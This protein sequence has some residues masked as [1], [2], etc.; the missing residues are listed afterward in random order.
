MTA[1][2][3]E[4]DKNKPAAGALPETDGSN[5]LKRSLINRAA[6]AGVL[7][8]ALLGGLAVLDQLNTPQP[9]K[10]AAPAPSAAST[11]PAS[12][13]APV[14]EAPKVEEPPAEQAVAAAD[15]AAGKKEEPTVEPESSAPPVVS[16]KPPKAEPTERPLTKPATPRLAM[17]KPSEPAVVPKQP[18]PQAALPQTTLIPHIP[19]SPRVSAPA[20]RPLTRATTQE[21]VF[22]LQLGVFS[23]IANAEELRAKLELNGIPAQVEA[24]IQ[25]GPFN[26]RLEVEQV[27]EKLRQIGLQ[28]G[29]LVTAKK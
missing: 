20:S 7:I 6:I 13:P 12:E 17:I 4:E 14:A 9:A 23:N 24:R 22:L 29:V 10:S 15:P 1:P 28:D 5:D 26:S 19:H 16:G 27:R 18:E 3:K 25:V 2:T 21:G 11:E 8:V